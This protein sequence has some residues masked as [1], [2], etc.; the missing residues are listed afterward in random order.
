M[1][2]INALAHRLLGNYSL[3]K[4]YA[5][6]LADLS[7]P[8]SNT[9]QIR[10]ITDSRELSGA[11]DQAL[12]S[13]AQ[14][15]AE[16]DAFCFGIWVEG[17][18]AAACWLWAGETYR[19]RRNFWPLRANEA[20]L[21]QITTAESFRGRGLA[22]QL[23]RFAATALKQQ[24]YERL[25]ARIW[26]SNTPSLTAFEKA[27]WTCVAFVAEFFPFGLKQPLRFVRRKQLHKNFQL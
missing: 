25:Y 14:Y 26:H 9:G 2:L 18:L 8:D 3:Y 24:G 21:V 12:R 7:A 4:I 17:E 6:P 1:K 27:G 15:A 20:K 5:L 13:L 10:Q 11:S 19:L 23:I 22:P 16:P